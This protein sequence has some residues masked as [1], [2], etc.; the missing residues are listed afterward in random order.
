MD[1]KL[2]KVLE[3]DESTFFYSYQVYVS[4]ELYIWAHA[5]SLLF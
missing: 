3:T 2:G 4:V 5:Q 1:K